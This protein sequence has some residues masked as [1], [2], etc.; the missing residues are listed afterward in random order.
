MFHI[1]I[2]ALSFSAA[3]GSPLFFGSEDWDSWFSSPSSI[4]DPQTLPQL[5]SISSEN[6]MPYWN[7]LSSYQVGPDDD[8]FGSV[9]ET[10]I[11]EDS[12][13]GNTLSNTGSSADNGLTTDF[14]ALRPQP[15]AT[16]D[17][18]TYADQ[19]LL[20]Q[21]PTAPSPEAKVHWFVPSRANPCP[22][23]ETYCCAAVQYT[24]LIYVNKET[25][26]PC[27]SYARNF[28]FI[29]PLSSFH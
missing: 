15:Q 21:I 8:M 4:A 7:E 2:L 16:T 12:D 17:F 19:N 3:M 13:L 5:N 26:K 25:C 10:F 23:I 24:L 28:Q 14:L 11:S 22:R 6:D 27:M 18:E 1:I 20:T 9:D 29:Y